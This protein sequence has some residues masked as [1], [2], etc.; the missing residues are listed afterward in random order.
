M[1]KLEDKNKN[2]KSRNA[3]MIIALTAKGK[4]PNSVIWI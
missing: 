3:E 4:S 1:G 2:E